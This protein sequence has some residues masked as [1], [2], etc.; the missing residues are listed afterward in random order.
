MCI[1]TYILYYLKETMFERRNFFVQPKNYFGLY[2]DIRDKKCP[3][4]IC[5]TLSMYVL[6]LGAAPNLTQKYIYSED[7][8]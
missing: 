8:G 7:N 6:S 3:S 2:Q 4:Q 5:F 1:C